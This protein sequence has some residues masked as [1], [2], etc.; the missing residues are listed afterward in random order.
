MDETDCHKKEQ[1]RETEK[2][3]E[4][5]FFLTMNE[6]EKGN[7]LPR[8]RKTQR[9]REKWKVVEKDGERNIS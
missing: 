8:E 5:N 1:C 4:G 7:R 3:G 9:E 6:A 2:D